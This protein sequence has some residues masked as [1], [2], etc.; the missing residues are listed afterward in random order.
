M[1]VKG[2]ILLIEDDSNDADVISTAIKEIGIPNEIKVMPSAKDAYDYL[3][4]TAEQPFLIMCDIRMPNVDGITFRRNI[5]Q[6][7]YLRK[8][9]IPFVFYTGLVSQE[10]VNEAYDL[11]VQGFFEKGAGYQKIKEQMLCIFMYWKQCLHP[12]KAI[13]ESKQA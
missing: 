12:N 3:C 1:A 10:I 11:D 7:E 9:S 13:I 2:P 8:K 5:I 4:T 6:S